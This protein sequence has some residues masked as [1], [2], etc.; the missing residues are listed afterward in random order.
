MLLLLAV[1]VL[2]SITVATTV[3]SWRFLCSWVL[4]GEAVGGYIIQIG[5]MKRK[6]QQLNNDHMLQYLLK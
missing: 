6:V 4:G 1:K 2:Y 5:G 3:I